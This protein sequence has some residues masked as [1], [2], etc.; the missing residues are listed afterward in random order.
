LR[1][2]GQGRERRQRVC[3][4]WLHALG[5]GSRTATACLR[6]MAACSEPGSRMA[7]R[8]RAPGWGHGRRAQGQQAAAVV[9]GVQRQRQMEVFGNFSKCWE[10]KR[11]A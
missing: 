1:A 2:P 6:L 5:Q 4:Q 9:F 3:D 10:R 8:S 11:G 7:A